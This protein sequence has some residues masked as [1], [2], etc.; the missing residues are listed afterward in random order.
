[1]YLVQKKLSGCNL[2]AS[3]FWYSR[4]W[5]CVLRCFSGGERSEVSMLSFGSMGLLYTGMMTTV[6][7]INNH[8]NGIPNAEEDES[9]FW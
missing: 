3:F 4:V 5:V 2:T 7:E 6:C 8:A 1:M 9:L